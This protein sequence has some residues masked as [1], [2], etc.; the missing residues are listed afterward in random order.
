MFRRSSSWPFSNQLPPPAQRNGQFEA[1]HLPPHPA[2]Q[3]GQPDP[4]RLPPA[5]QV[6]QLETRH[7]ADGK[8]LL[9]PCNKAFGLMPLNRPA[10]LPPPHDCPI[11]GQSR[12]HFPASPS[13]HTIFFLLTR[14]DIFRVHEINPWN[15]PRNTIL[16]NKILPRHNC[17]P[18]RIL[19]WHAV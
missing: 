4:S 19:P 3:V 16:T 15:L 8:L 7:A 11:V 10:L 1:F 5:H 17:W 9:T 14:P 2:H 18:V 13:L 12:A 6:G